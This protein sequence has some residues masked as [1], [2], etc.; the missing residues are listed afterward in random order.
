MFRLF[1][2]FAA[3]ILSACAA[4]A[5]AEPLPVP[6]EGEGFWAIGVTGIHCYRAPCPWRGIAPI[7]S[8]GSA[9][10]PLSPADQPAPPPLRASKADRARI[11]AAYAQDCLVVEGHFEGETL[12]VAR[13]LAQCDHWFK[14]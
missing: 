3:L 9:G 2:P 14:T 10:S 11:D 4:S 1:L 7:A 5:Q 13:V 8:D 12:V 6:S